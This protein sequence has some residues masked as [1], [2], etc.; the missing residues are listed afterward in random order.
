M[1]AFPAL[2]LS[3]R[4]IGTIVNLA[5]F[6]C[7]FIG[8]GWTIKLQYGILAVLVLSIA[9]F[10]AGAFSD[11]SHATLV[12]NLK[13][14]FQNGQSLLTMFALFFPAV[15]GIMAGADMSGDLK[16]P[17]RSI[18]RGTLAAVG[19][20]ALVYSGIALLLAASRSQEALIADNLIMKDIAW[21]PALISL[22]IFAATL[23]SALG[24]MMGAPWILQAFWYQVRPHLRGLILPRQSAT[25]GCTRT[26]P[27]SCYGFTFGVSARVTCTVERRA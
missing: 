14:N 23:S 10:C 11:I 3:M 18:P 19:F 15:T 26:F 2:G 16:D 5:V 20:T 9:S 22:G 7:V 17:A 21:S 6:L 8:A 1:A 13:P 27:G 12:S 4:T 24:S 25:L